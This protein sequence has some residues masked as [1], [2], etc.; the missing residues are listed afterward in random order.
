MRMCVKYS[1]ATQLTLNVSNKRHAKPL[2][3]H[4]GDVP[5]RAQA[6]AQIRIFCAYDAEYD[7]FSL[8]SKS[9]NV[10]LLKQNT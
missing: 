9:E 10:F 7:S 2:Y 5:G 1:G 4:H 8:S 6:A 3:Y